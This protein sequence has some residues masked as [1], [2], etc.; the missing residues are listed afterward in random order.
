M[1]WRVLLLVMCGDT[2]SRSQGSGRA[3]AGRHVY[4]DILLPGTSHD[5]LSHSAFT[6][7]ASQR[8]FKALTNAA[9]PPLRSR[10]CDS[11]SSSAP[12][13]ICLYSRFGKQ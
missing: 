4:S 10:Y 9:R 6:Q 8:G 2:D 7:T 13:D 12:L 5:T 11:I 1:A 3:D